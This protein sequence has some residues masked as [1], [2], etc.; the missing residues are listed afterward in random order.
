MTDGIHQR[1]DHPVV[2]IILFSLLTQ[3]ANTLKIKKEQ[4]PEEP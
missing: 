2:R 4:M 3:G 1:I